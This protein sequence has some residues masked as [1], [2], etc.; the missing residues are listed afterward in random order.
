M[1][2]SLP[3]RNGW[4]G[5]E[6]LVLFQGLWIY[7][8]MLP[9]IL[10]AQQQFQAQPAD[11]IV[12]SAP[13]T[14][15]TWLKS[16]IFATMTRTSFDDSTSPLL[17]KMPHD[18]VPFME[19]DHARFCTHRELGVPLL[20]THVP[21]SLLP[22]SIID[23]G[24]KIVYICRDP[25]D[26]LFRY[27][28]SLP[29]ASYYGPYW[30]HVLGYWKASLEHPERFLFFKYEELM[31]DTVLYVTKLA[32]FIGHPFSSEE[33]RKGM[34]EKI[35]EMCSFDH[36]SNLEANKSGIHRDGMIENKLYFGKGWLGT[37]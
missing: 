1:I 20:A 28:I 25:K 24:C 16:L 37:G 13:K 36:L 18:V 23:S 22:Q 4:G 8:F 30:D 15:T 2:P 3:K 29:G 10:S 7:P 5:N 33:Q 21:H 35:V 27:I 14:G 11:I 32:T 12:C 31:E 19:F 6:D 26:T 17:S 34:P 9:G